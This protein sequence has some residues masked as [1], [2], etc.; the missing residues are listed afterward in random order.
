MGLVGIYGKFIHR[1]IHTYIQTYA[2]TCPGELIGCPH[3]A[4]L[5]LIGCPPEG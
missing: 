1:Y 2:N 3:C 5:R 4:V